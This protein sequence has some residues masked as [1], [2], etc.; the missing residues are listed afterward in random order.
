MVCVCNDT[1]C[2]TVESN[3]KLPK[4]KFAVYSSSQDGLRLHKQILEFAS[5]V[6]ATGESI[7]SVNVC[8]QI[9]LGCKLLLGEGTVES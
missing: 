8:I 1:Y 7:M 9:C 6:N 4:G 2:D 3:N 5:G